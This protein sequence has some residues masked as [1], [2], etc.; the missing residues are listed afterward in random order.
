MIHRSWRQTNKTTIV[1][2]SVQSYL[3]ASISQD[4]LDTLNK[5]RKKDNFKLIVVAKEVK[6]FSMSPHD[7]IQPNSR[8]PFTFMISTQE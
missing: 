7:N 6:D 8:K 4:S 5:R 1:I 3:Q 2:D